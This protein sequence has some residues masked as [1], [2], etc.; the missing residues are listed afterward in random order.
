[1]EQSYNRIQGKGNPLGYAPI[2]RLIAKF[3]IPSIIS[4]LVTAAYNIT[5]QIFKIGRAHV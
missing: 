1:M 4:M 2:A 5:D 3:A